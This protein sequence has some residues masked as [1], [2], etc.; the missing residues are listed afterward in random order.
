MLEE[1]LPA[2]DLLSDSKVPDRSEVAGGAQ[3]H[4]RVLNGILI[5]QSFP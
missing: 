5:S 1:E 2:F 3:Q 4:E